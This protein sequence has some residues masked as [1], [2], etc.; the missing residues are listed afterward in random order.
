MTIGLT[1]ITGV[2]TVDAAGHSGVTISG[3]AGDDTIDLSAAT[4]IGI[5]AIGGGAGNDVIRTGAGND[6]LSGGLG[7]DQ[8]YGGLGNDNYNFTA[9]DGDDV[10]TDTGG[11]D[12]LALRDIDS[13]DVTVTYSTDGLDYILTFAGSAGSIR[14]AGAASGGTGRIERVGFVGGVVWTDAMLTAMAD[15]NLNQIVGTSGNDTLTGTSAADVLVGLGGN[16]SLNGGL[17]IDIARFAGLQSSYSIVT[18][19]GTTT[20]VDLAPSV[21]GNDGTDTLIAIEKAEFK[22]G[23]QVGLAVPV[24]LD[25]NGDGV[26]LVNVTFSPARFDWDGDGVRDK[27]GWVSGG[28]GILVFDRDGDGHVSGANELSFVNDKPGAKS[29]LDGLSA[30]DSNGDGVFST[31]DVR[32]SDF[33]IWADANS[34]GTV[35]AGELVSLAQ[36]NVASIDLTGDAMNRSW[37]WGENITVNT[38]GFTKSDG[39]KG[40]LSD[41]AL[42]YEVALFAPASQTNTQHEWI[43]AVDQLPPTVN[44]FDYFSG[45]ASFQCGLVTSR[46]RGGRLYD[47]TPLDVSTETGSVDAPLDRRIALMAQDMAAFGGS[48]REGRI[49]LRA[50]RESNN[51]EYFA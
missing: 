9:G 36:A 11:D 37:S 6:M 1:S 10:I 50:N 2:E 25:L 28:D 47:A 15:A 30:F 42:T 44:P 33:R 43:S 31:A 5:G 21:D 41:V 8:L 4:L 3:S 27:T 32:W 24:I 39:S 14:L 7:N 13:P 22:N 18:V 23:V 26:T 34:D 16:D 19:S 46:Q 35:D 40:A 20:I 38:G 17:G 51:Y 29:D 48:G 45:D 49:E 12:F